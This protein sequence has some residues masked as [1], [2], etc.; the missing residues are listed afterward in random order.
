[1]SEGELSRGVVPPASLAILAQSGAAAGACRF[2]PIPFVDDFLIAEIHRR[3][4][5]SLLKRH[6]FAAGRIQEIRPLYGMSGGCFWGVLMF[7]LKLPFKLILKL[8]QK[9][10]KVIL[11]VLI[12]RDSGLQI[13][14]TIMLG[15]VADRC[16]SDGRLLSGGQE[17]SQREAEA[18]ITAFDKAF[19]GSDWRLL[20]KFF[21]L[22]GEKKHQPKNKSER[23]TFQ[24]KVARQI[25]AILEEPRVEAYMKE[26]DERFDQYL[27]ESS[28]K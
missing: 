17:Q 9:F 8:I 28:K 15:R 5:L 24:K 10:L 23:E 14:R 25:Y 3:M 20:A 1:M 13:G 22:S 21:K 4:F 26:F 7:I 16:L 18:V 19:S 12:I 11:F 27:A 6:G 2:I